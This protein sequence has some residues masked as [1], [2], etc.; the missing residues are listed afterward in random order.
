MG[1][2]IT[3]DEMKKKFPNEWLLITD[4]DLDK[5]GHV[6]AGVVDRHSKEKDDVYRFPALNKSTAFRFTGKSTFIGLRSHAGKHNN[7]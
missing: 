3:W 4:Y 7:V 5:S 1:T 2:K 6:L